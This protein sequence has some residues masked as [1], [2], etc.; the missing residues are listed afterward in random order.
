MEDRSRRR[1]E[2]K[3][4]R[5]QAQ[6][7]Q[8][9]AYSTSNSNSTPSTHQASRRRVTLATS[10]ASDIDS[11]HRL[12]TVQS[13]SQPLGRGKSIRERVGAA[14]GR[15]QSNTTGS[16]MPPHP[17][18]NG[19]HHRTQ[20]LAPEYQPGTASGATGLNR[21][22][23]GLVRKLSRRIATD[24]RRDDQDFYAGQ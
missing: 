12:E 10:H 15:F 7:Q 20:S 17:N 8:P 13:A 9:P 1:H 2:R 21:S 11:F 23:T 16:R 18:H 22:L 24:D 3:L 5:Q 19:G 4:A 14:L 6:A